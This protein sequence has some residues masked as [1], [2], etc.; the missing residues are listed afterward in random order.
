MIEQS[1]QRVTAQ[2]SEGA[3]GPY[4]RAIRAHGIIVPL[5]TLAAVLAAVAF[6]ATRSPTYQATTE[7][8]VSPVSADDGTFFGVQILRDTPGDPTRAVQTAATLADSPLAARIAAQRLGSPW[9]V[10]SV[11][12]AVTVQPQGQSNILAVTAKAGDAK[13]AAHVA[14][15]FATATLQV[16]ANALKAQVKTLLSD[17][18]TRQKLLKGGDATT[19]AEL[20]GRINALQSLQDGV[21]PTL[22]VLQEARTPTAPVGASS[23]MI[24]GLALIAGF[25]LATGAALLIEMLD[26][27]IRDQ[28]ELLHLY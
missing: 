10:D 14:N 27:R 17:L 11:D 2:R 9:T 6:V 21:D 24:I 18:E 26:R 4:L 28:E 23:L 12:S 13:E 7:M 25:I 15:E 22:S 5:I 3:L 20:A 1:T 19:R 8:L 16:R